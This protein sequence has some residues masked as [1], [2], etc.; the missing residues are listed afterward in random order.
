MSLVTLTKVCLSFSCIEKATSLEKKSTFTKSHVL[1][2]GVRD[3]L[4]P[5]VELAHC[6]GKALHLLKPVFVPDWDL[7]V[8]TE[9]VHVVAKNQ[10]SIWMQNTCHYIVLEKNTGWKS[11][12]GSSSAWL[13]PVLNLLSVHVDCISHCS[14]S[15]RTEFAEVSN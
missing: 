9:S 15:L 4:S 6:S 3:P 8:W 1:D 14:P 2:L 11:L 5:E 13:C 7:V 12:N 10:E